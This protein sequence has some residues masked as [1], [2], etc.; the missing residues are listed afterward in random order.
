MADSG[1]RWLFGVGDEQR[2][3]I[4]L[5]IWSS[6]LLGCREQGLRLGV[7]AL[8]RRRLFMMFVFLFLFVVVFFG[9]VD[10][11]RGED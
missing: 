5:K 10:K 2:G 7:V 3:W 4:R 9:G 8:W 1:L 11:Q 6:G